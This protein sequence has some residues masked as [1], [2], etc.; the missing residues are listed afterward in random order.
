[1]EKNKEEQLLEGLIQELRRGT[2]VLAVL[3]QLKS[4]QYGYSLIVLMKEKGLDL[5]ANTLY[6]LLRR[7]EKQGILESL[8]DTDGTKP[9]KYYKLSVLGETVY[10][11][12]CEAWKDIN[13]VVNN[14][15]EN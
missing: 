12:L 6:P 8:W 14:L 7:L 11:K 15:I 1:M 9:R 10:L 3:S 13:N 5:E 2:I 4:P